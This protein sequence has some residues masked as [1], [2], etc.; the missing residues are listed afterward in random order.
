VFILY[1]VALGLVLGLIFG[2]QFDRL[3]NVRLH[4]W[5]LAIV[6]F[7]IQLALFSPAG[8][9]IP[10]DLAALLYVAST[11][12]VLAVVIRNVRLPGLALIALG[13]GL[14]L[15]AIVANGGRMPADP[16][17]LVAAGRASGVGA[18]SNGSVVAH[19]ALAPLTDIFA[20]P[21]GV[22]LANVFSFGD[23]LIG[24]GLVIALVALMRSGGQPTA[25]RVVHPR[26]GGA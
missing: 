11:V 8:D 23:V 14:N 20:I 2:G 19:P 21:A 25:D 18:N 9:R 3:G 13:A 5:P 17:A 10:D 7:V 4:W 26:D 22:P 15:A 16:G 12:T 1:G 24:L 6:G